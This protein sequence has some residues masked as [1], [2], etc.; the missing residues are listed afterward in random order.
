V[1]CRKCHT[2]QPPISA[3]CIKCGKPLQNHA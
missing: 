1:E 2:V 3:K